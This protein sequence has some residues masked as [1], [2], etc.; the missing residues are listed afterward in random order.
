MFD[1]ITEQ[2]DARMER[3][4]KNGRIIRTNMELNGTAGRSADHKR[5]DDV[6]TRDFPSVC[7]RLVEPTTVR[8][9][10]WDSPD[11]ETR[12]S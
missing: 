10:G 7:R 12:S 1:W 2:V 8:H 6:D 5:C 9:A 4:Q 3:M 11:S